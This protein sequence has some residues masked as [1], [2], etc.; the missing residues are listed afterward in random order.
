MKVKAKEGVRMSDFKEKV[1]DLTVEEAIE[2]N[3]AAKWYC[4]HE[5]TSEAGDE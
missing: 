5:V 2:L 3:N 1:K 4:G